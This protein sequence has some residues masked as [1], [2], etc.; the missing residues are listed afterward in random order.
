MSRTRQGHAFYVLLFNRFKM[1]ALWRI[2]VTVED[3]CHATLRK[4]ESKRHIFQKMFGIWDFKISRFLCR[5]LHLS[6][7]FLDIGK[8]YILLIFEAKKL[9]YLLNRYLI[10]V[11][12]FQWSFFVIFIFSN[13]S[14]SGF[15]EWSR[16]W[17]SFASWF[18]RR[19]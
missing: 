11:R 18:G 5:N 1:K 9:S 8:T 15:S 2:S 7:L 4:N 17:A 14:F 16:T 12:V 3:L 6:T 10:F 19:V 13:P